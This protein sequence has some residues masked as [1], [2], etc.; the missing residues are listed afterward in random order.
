MRSYTRTI[1]KWILSLFMICLLVGFGMIEVYAAGYSDPVSVQI[2]YTHI[3]DAEKNRT[4]DTFNY[5]ITPIGEAPA[6]SDNAGGAYAFSVKGVPEGSA[7]SGNV[8]LSIKFDR[9]GEYQ[10]KL[11][12]SDRTKD[13][14]TFES[15]T[16]TI[17]VFVKNDSNGG[18]TVEDI[19][20]VD[21]SSNKKVGRLTLNPSHANEQLPAEEARP[22][23]T[24]RGDGTVPARVNT[25]GQPVAGTPA[26]S[27]A[28]AD[29]GTEIESEPTPLE[30]IIDK[31]LPKAD[32]E[33]HYW[34][35]LNLISA[36][37]TFL[38]SGI[39][40]YRYFERIDT[41][42]DEYIIRRKGNLR[43][44]GIVLSIISIATFLLTEDLSNPM[45]LVDEWTPFMIGV[46]AI[47]LVLA[48]IVYKRYGNGNA[49]GEAA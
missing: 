41:E 46:L 4:N 27:G 17:K 19:V 45:G 49:E 14:F 3:Y 9:P 48:L 8:D 47:D 25:N 33:R 6:L 26:A 40:V 37:L 30:N 11:A 12:S 10:Y 32:P 22:T 35:L 28:P 44:A 39:M 1:E 21:N 2:P 20:V 23:T 29:P 16:Y 34:A 36:I 13:G 43:L 31:A 24:P 7:Q 38:A 42:E 5:R 15:R 18:L